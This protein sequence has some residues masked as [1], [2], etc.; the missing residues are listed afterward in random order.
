MVAAAPNFRG[1]LKILDQNNWGGDLSKKLNWG[2]GGGMQH[3]TSPKLAE[4]NLLI[5]WLAW[6]I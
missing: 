2:E 5:R 6:L 3:F 1:A 4:A